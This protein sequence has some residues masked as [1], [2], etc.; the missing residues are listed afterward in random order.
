MIIDPTDRA[1]EVGHWHFD[2]DDQRHAGWR[3][4]HAVFDRAHR[5][6]L[7]RFVRRV[8]DG[9]R[10]AES[11]QS[12]ETVVQVA[13]AR[14][15][16][17]WPEIEAMDNPR[18]W[19]YKVAYN[20]VRK[21]DVN[22]HEV[23]RTRAV[24]PG[25]TSGSA[26]G[27]AMSA[28]V[29]LPQPQRTALVLFDVEGFPA[30][31]V[32][33]ILGCTPE[34]VTSLVRG[35]RTTLRRRVSGDATLHFRLIG[36]RSWIG[37]LAGGV[38]LLV[39]ASGLGRWLVEHLR[40]ISVHPVPPISTLLA[41]LSY[42]AATVAVVLKMTASYRAG[43]RLRRLGDCLLRRT[44]PRSPDGGPPR[45]SGDQRRRSDRRRRRR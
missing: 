24:V 21:A 38:V 6:P 26:R 22:R 30:K 35:G 15:A 10:L 7:L 11:E 4:R 19:L 13:L 27:P 2:P 43:R 20:L 25:W 14:A 45:P 44:R 39:L 29:D 34:K 3:A 5:A 23:R 37:G 28:L 8:A 33:E 42:L 36:R 41:V 17:R 12:P 16:L 40:E 31:E 9:R 32:A 1:S 18:A